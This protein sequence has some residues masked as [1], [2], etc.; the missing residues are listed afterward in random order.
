MRPVPTNVNLYSGAGI[1]DVRAARRRRVWTGRTVA[2]AVSLGGHLLILLAIMWAKADSLKLPSTPGPGPISVALIKG[3]PLE[4]AVAPPVPEPTPKPVVKPEPPHPKASH[5]PVEPQKARQAPPQPNSRYAPTSEASVSDTANEP[6]ET[7]LA[8]AATASSGSPGGACNMIR[9][10]Q[11]AL[12]K[13]AAIRAAVAE[14]DRRVSGKAIMLWNGDWVTSRGED[15][16]GLANVREVMMVEIAFAPA[17]CKTG[18]VHGLVRF[19]LN[20]APGATRL[21]V[22][23]GVWRWSDLLTPHPGA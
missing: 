23:S 19:S 7:Q 11:D 8:E 12:R 14:A 21:M 15:G 5:K 13:D 22:G 18:V 16:K 20:D 1:G 10:L 9:L 3:P 2:V 17:A 4:V 6:S